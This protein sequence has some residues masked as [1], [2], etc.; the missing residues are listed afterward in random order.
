[1]ST[2][3]DL[4]AFADKDGHFRRQ[5][6]KFRDWISSEAGARFPPEKDRYVLYINWG[7]PWANRTAIVRMLKGLE[8]IIE[9]VVMDYIMFAEGW[10]YSGRD[11]TAEKDPFY[12]FTRH[13]QL[14]EKAE[15]GYEGRVLVPTLWDKKNETIVNNESSEIIRMFYT[16]FDDLLPEEF[17]EKSHPGGGYYP[18]SL[19]GQIDQFNEWVYDTINNGVYKCGFA[20]SQEAYDKNVVILFDS[21][22]RVEGHL[23]KSDGPFL[24]G[25][26][27]TEADI[28]LY[29]SIARFDVAYHTIF[30]CNMKMI[31]HDYPNI[32]KWYRNIYYDEGD[33]TRGGAFRKATHWDAIKFGYAGAKKMEVVPKGPV[34]DILPKD[35]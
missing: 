15:A 32:D 22:D 34:P 18:A 14:Y 2:K 24:F 3:E 5:P 33:E 19:K 4:K 23:E 29:P 10:G 13:R 7:C 31:R 35:A 8:N 20:S 25:K 21:L 11:G 16:E 27:V 30:K 1:M 6:S 12:G 26:R 28:R 17:Q 9:L